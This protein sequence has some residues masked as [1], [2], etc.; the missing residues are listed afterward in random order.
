MAASMDASPDENRMIPV[1]VASPRF[2]GRTLLLTNILFGATASTATG[3]KIAMF[4]G[5]TAQADIIIEPTKTA[6]KASFFIKLSSK[7]E[8]TE[9]TAPPPDVSS[10]TVL[11]YKTNIK[12][13]SVFAADSSFSAS[14]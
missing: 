11:R 10:I 9:G 2:K 6:N 4:C 8:S 13:Q 14:R 3:E 7:Y 5:M 1:W 12:N